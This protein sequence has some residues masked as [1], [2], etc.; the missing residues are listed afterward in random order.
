[1]LGGMTWEKIE[2]LKQEF[3]SDFSIGGISMFFKKVTSET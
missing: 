1:L 3:Q 2:L